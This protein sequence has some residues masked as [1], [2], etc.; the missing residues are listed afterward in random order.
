MAKR[1]GGASRRRR[2]KRMRRPQAEGERRND[3]PLL[4]RKEREAPHS[5]TP[6]RQARRIGPP[7]AWHSVLEFAA[8]AT[9][10]R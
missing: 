2:G 4:G 7:I 8:V 3:G 1:A 10:E 5:G 6:P 9:P